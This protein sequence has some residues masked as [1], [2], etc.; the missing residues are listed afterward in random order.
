MSKNVNELSNAAKTG[1]GK[2]R[3]SSETLRVLYC[4]LQ[5]E[6]GDK[7]KMKRENRE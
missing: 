7:K 1:K 6:E 2:K 5:I 4:W 3:G